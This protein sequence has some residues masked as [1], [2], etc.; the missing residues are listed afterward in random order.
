MFADEVARE[1]DEFRGKAS[2][3]E[4]LELPSEAEGAVLGLLVTDLSVREIGAQLFLSPNTVRSHIRSIY[5]KLSVGSRDDAV[6]RAESIGL[7]S[8]TQSPR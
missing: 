5:R 6:A 7:L 8:E 3:G 4:I 2:A 1:L